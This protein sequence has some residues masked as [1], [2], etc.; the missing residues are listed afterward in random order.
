MMGMSK[1]FLA[2]IAVNGFC[3]GEC[4]N[5]SRDCSTPSCDVVVIWPKIMYST[6]RDGWI[7]NAR[8]LPAVTIECSN[9]FTE[10]NQPWGPPFT[11]MVTRTLIVPMPEA[12]RE[13][14]DRE[15]EKHNAAAELKQ[16]LLDINRRGLCADKEDH[17][18]HLV[19]TGSLAPYWCTA[20]QSTREPFASE[21]RRRN[22]VA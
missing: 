9:R 16:V 13:A 19:L 5:G 12:M 3:G 18:P 8:E 7:G 15:R 21:Q 22:N 6:I 20:I 14:Y 17:D 10:E 4:V 2:W 1:E 11:R